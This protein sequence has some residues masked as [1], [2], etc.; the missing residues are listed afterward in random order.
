MSAPQPS[1]TNSAIA[2]VIALGQERDAIELR[3]EIA[4]AEFIEASLAL[5]RFGAL[6]GRLVS[7]VPDSIDLRLYPE[8]KRE[9]AVPRLV[10]AGEMKLSKKS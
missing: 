6:Y 5:G 1:S 8:T 10:T 3:Y 7:V 4:R 2:R 9:P